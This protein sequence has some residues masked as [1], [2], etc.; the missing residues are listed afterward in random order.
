MKRKGKSLVDRV[1]YAERRAADCERR[2][3]DM[4]REMRRCN[5]IS[6]GSQILCSILAGMIGPEFHVPA[7]AVEAGKRNE[8]ACRMNSDGT[9]DFCRKDI[10][11]LKGVLDM[12]DAGPDEAGDADG[13]H[14]AG[15][16]ENICGQQG[17]VTI[18][19][20]IPDR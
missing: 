16:V 17:T 2:M 8:Y 18:E 1:E 3:R 7:D 15:G 12:D 10:L 5:A 20:D 13:G 4:H 6:D 11:E 19:D 14:G 9:Y